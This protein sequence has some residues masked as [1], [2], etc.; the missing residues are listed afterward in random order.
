MRTTR[1]QSTRSFPHADRASFRGSTRSTPIDGSGEISVDEIIELLGSLD[2]N[3]KSLNVEEVVRAADTD[4]SGEIDFDEFFEAMKAPVAF[5]DNGLTF[6]DLV[7]T[8]AHPADVA[9]SLDEANTRFLAAFNEFVCDTPTTNGGGE[10]ETNAVHSHR[11]SELSIS[12]AV[13]RH[14][15]EFADAA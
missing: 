11:Q 3:A 8:A 10:T 13:L 12:D 14:R 15:P 9:R 1:R 6:A 2:A 5:G 4:Q 7:I